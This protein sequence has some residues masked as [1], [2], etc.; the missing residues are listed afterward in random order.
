MNS[1]E[2]G[3]CA[4]AASVGRLIWFIQVINNKVRNEKL[5]NCTFYQLR[6]EGKLTDRTEILEDVTVKRS[7]LEQWNNKRFL[8]R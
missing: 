2:S 6:Q 1:E 3:L 8:Q 7:L 5:A 4:V